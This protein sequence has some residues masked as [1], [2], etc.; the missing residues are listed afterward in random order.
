MNRKDQK[1]GSQSTNLQAD[2]MIV[3]VGIDEKRAREV[4]R[5]MIS[6][7]KQDYTEEALRV[8]NYRVSEFERRFMP[9]MEQVEGALEIFS[10]PSFQLL[11]VEAQRAAAS[12]E[13]EVDYDLLSEL[14][15]YRF[16]QGD[17]RKSRAGITLAVDV[18]D[19]ISDDA[20]L[21][22]TVAH[23][24]AVLVPLVPD[25]FNGLDVLDSLFGRLM[26][27]ELPKGDDWLDQLDV[28]RVI[29]IRPYETLR[30]LDERYAEQ[31]SGYVDVGIRVGS[32]NHAKA[33]KMLHENRLPKDFLVEHAFNS[34]YVRIPVYQ[35]NQIKDLTVEMDHLEGG[36]I[37][38]RVFQLSEQQLKVMNSIYD[39]YVD[40]DALRMKN[41][42]SFS[43]E[44]GNRSNL[45][46]IKKWLGNLPFAFSIT[47]IGKVLAH[48]NAQRCDGRVPSL[49]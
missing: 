16:K 48:S 31:L 39:L 22:L 2:Q 44:W 25:P 19:K 13:R 11:L 32:E 18:V 8:A 33:L 37:S 34:E 21:G 12:T 43:R 36:A 47:S 20:L 7:L 23:A 41:M 9:K 28:L 49:Y 24:A 3:Q 45:S 1:G 4:F 5:E 35:R 27:G 10:D 40:D 30:A 17:S 6:Q 38:T 15:V 14:L 26:Y 29:R 42:R 46:A